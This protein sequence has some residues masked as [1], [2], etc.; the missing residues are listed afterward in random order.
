MGSKPDLALVAV[1][2]ASAILWIE[3][4][5]I[6]V[7][8]PVR[9]DL[10]VPEAVAPCPASDDKPYDATC[11]AFLQGPSGS[12]THLRIGAVEGVART[13]AIS[14]ATP[15]PC[16]DNDN[17]PYSASCLAFLRGATA[18]GMRWRIHA[19]DPGPLPAATA[20]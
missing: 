19:T 14:A 13:D 11:L 7:E 16:P 4:S 17:V 10:S 2:A 6:V 1:V 18:T 3:H 15:A 5:R 12:A 20:K 9:A 8:A